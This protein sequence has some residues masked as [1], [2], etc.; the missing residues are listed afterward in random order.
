MKGSSAGV[1]Q[2]DNPRASRAFWELVRNSGRVLESTIKGTSMHP[3]IP[4]GARVRIRPLHTENYRV[5]QIVACLLN[6]EIFAHRV[7]FCGSSGRSRDMVL[8]RGDALVMCDPPTRKSAILGEVT[9]FWADGEWRALNATGTTLPRY[10][11]LALL[12]EQLIRICMP[13]HYEFAR[14]VA[15]T[16]LIVGSA[17]GRLLSGRRGG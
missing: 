9:E 5:G 6:D 7:V 17:I 1:S 16:T 12:Q 10:R 14:R 11:A 15:G 8:T 2:G 3:T 4:D 13:V